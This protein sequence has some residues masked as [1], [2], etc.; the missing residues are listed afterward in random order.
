MPHDGPGAC[1]LSKP[2]RPQKRP[3]SAHLDKHTASQAVHAGAVTSRHGTS[4]S[5]GAGQ[6]MSAGLGCKARRLQCLPWQGSP[7]AMPFLAHK[8]PALRHCVTGAA[9]AVSTGGGCEARLALDEVV[10]IDAGG[11]GV[12]GLACCDV[13]ADVATAR[14]LLLQRDDRVLHVQRCAIV[15][16]GRV[17]VPPCVTSS[18][19]TMTIS[20]P[21]Q[22]VRSC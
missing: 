18:S 14:H 15:L 9:V 4:R 19:S 7:V 1:R 16:L 11:G 3:G 13:Q 8:A 17:Q 21:C 2:D 12:A 10:V 20:C 6:Q 5:P 22:D